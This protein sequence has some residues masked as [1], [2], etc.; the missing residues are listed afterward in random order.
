MALS[1]GLPPRLVVVLLAALV[2]LLGVASLPLPPSGPPAPLPFV[3][4]GPAPDAPP[5]LVV[6]TGDPGTAVSLLWLEG[7]ATAP[8][9]PAGSRLAL[10][11]AGGVLV[12]DSRLRVTRPRLRLDG[13]EPRSVAAGPGGGFW[14]TDGT[15][16]LVGLD[17]TGR[18]VSVAAAPFAYPA[19]S[20]DPSSGDLWMVRSAEQFAYQGDTAAPLLARQG[21]GGRAPRPLGRA[22]RPEHFL[23]TDLANAGHVAAAAGVVYYAPFIRDQ[24]M[25]LTP[26]GDT[27][28]TTTRGLPQTT[29]EPRFEV[30]D[31]KVVIDYHPVNLGIALGPDGHLYVLSTPDFTMTESRLDVLDP[32]SGQVLRT[33]RLATARPTLAVGRG[34]RVHLL[35]G[36]RLLQGVPERERAPAPRL[37]LPLLAGGRLSPAMLEGRVVVLNFWASWCAPCRTEMPA[38]DTLRRSIEDT[39]F[40]FVAVSEDKDTAAARAFIDGFGFTFP[41]ALGRGTLRSRIHYPGL[42]YTVLLDR[43]GRIAGR[44]IGF[45]GQDQL[46]AM[47]ALIRSELHQAGLQGERHRHGS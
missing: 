44:W 9:R 27:L 38:L 2:A 35:E 46:Q 40:V 4:P 25:A 15:G 7:R 13:R 6:D 23:L 16:Q 1:P 17:N 14:V 28:W 37:D 41:V 8:A 3:Q 24:V 30:R 19:V 18:V 12:I 42:P 5:R 34:G 39:G 45:A 22:V 11:G 43:S 29:I 20:S 10:D 21:G 26:V 47:R 36:S 31:G 33:A 32:G